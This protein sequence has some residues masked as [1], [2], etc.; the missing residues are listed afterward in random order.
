MKKIIKPWVVALISI[1]V[2]VL[3]YLVIALAFTMENFVFGISISAI[4]PAIVAYP[5]S[6]VIYKSHKKINIQKIEIEK[7]HE[8]IRD[9]INY[10]SRIQKAL[11]PEDKMFLENFSSY[12]ILNKPKDIVSGDF[13]YF[14]K[15]EEQVI[16]AVAD[17]TGHGVPGAFVSMLGISFLNEIINENKISNAAQILE[18][19][20]IKV[21][22]SLKQIDKNSTNRD[23]MDISLC[24]INT[25]TNK[26]SFSGA[27]NP[28]YIFRDNNLKDL[29][30]TRN[31]IGFYPKEVEFKNNEIQL[32]KQDKIYMFS[33]GYTDQFGGEE[34]TF[35]I[36][37]FRELL[38]TIHRKSL[39]E[40]KTI[41]NETIEKWQGNK[42]EQTDDILIVG[43]E[44]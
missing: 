7:S 2:S 36:K 31:P 13:Y 24:V 27:N 12:F 11:L 44:I 1:V 39:I 30:A 14:K 34:T 32:Q 33:D 42:F 3:I 8:K 23:G 41:L 4:I 28:L 19:L 15:K 43:I 16:I 29:K 9:S 10:A 18:E 40:Q 26:L 6:N 20:R 21:K 38:K 37:K 22:T 35:K 25:E 5:I 17:C